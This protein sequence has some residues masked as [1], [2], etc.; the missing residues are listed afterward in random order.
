MDTELIGPGRVFTNWFGRDF[1]DGKV[2]SSNSHGS[3][4]EHYGVAYNL[5]SGRARWGDGWINVDLEADAD[6]RADVR[7]LSMIASDS[8][9]AVAAIH[10]LEHFYFWEAKDL[11]LEWRRIL[12]P[13]GKMII[14]VP[15]LDKIVDYIGQ[16]LAANEN[17]MEFMTLHALYGDPKHK[18]PL[19]AHKFGWFRA[20]LQ[21]F[22]G[23]CGMREITIKTAHYH[24]PQRDCRFECIK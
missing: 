1:R 12:K 16:C 10:V 23:E 24:F 9:D 8:A 3:L 7:D 2:F 15:C 17:I 6:I 14:E 13:G 11:I 4:E 22:L 19:M 21:Q 20:H 18:N 5:G